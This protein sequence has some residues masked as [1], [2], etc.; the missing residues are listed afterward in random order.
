MSTLSLTANWNY[1]TSIKVGV[2]RVR[3]LVDACHALGMKSPLLVTD[4]NLAKL[5]MIESVL[6]NCRDAGLLIA[7]FAAVKA[8]PTGENVMA[9]VDIYRKGQHDGVIAI[10]GGSALDAGKAIALMVGQNCS[11]WDFEDIGDNWRR[12]NVAGMA[13]V[14]ALPS[15]AG[16]GSEVGRASV[17]TDTQ[18]QRKKIIFHPK[19][20]PA[21][22][23]LDPELTVALPPSITAAT[24]MDAL[25]HCLEAY[26]APG[27]HPLAEGIAL[28]GIRLIK[29]HLPRVMQNGRDIDSRTQMLVASLMGATAFQRGLGA[30]HAL[31]HPLG[32]I[33]DAHHGRLNAILM[34][35]ILQANR[36]EI[37]H[38]ITRLAAY[39]EIDNGFDGFLNWILQLRRELG[40][41][42][43]LSEIGIDEQHATRIAIM[44]TEDPSAQSN[45]ILFDQQQYSNILMAALHGDDAY[46]SKIVG[47]RL[48]EAP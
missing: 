43:C 39:L 4:S 8:N 25:S 7:L 30:M 29:E 18:Q 40:I 34:P 10:G 11:L 21:L 27:Y 36:P 33:Y 2:G 22:V 16:T 28:E 6:K 37:E 48:A 13:P 20:L 9:G 12:V 38:K 32:A 41:E 14:I 31:A 3:E 35:Y 44:A 5:P 19:M 17:I 15:T 23:I 45:P 26:S 1:P 47:M 24:G 42:H 46:H